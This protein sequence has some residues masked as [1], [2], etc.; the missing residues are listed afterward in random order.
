M[1][2][3]GLPEVIRMRHDAHYVETLA[4]SAGVPVGRMVAIDQV[5]PNPDQPRQAMGDL[6]ELIASVTEKGVIQPLV[7]RQ[8][9][10]RYQIIAGERRYQAAVQAG[11][12]ELPVVVR[13]V[14]NRRR[15][16]AWRSG[17]ATPMKTWPSAWA[18]PGQPSPK[19][20]R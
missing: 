8:R 19:R 1:P 18:S 4:A 14:E 17:A 5:D 16:R 11:L 10:A 13:D 7:V 15:C 9:G 3:R 12:Q 20:C 2:K 6:A